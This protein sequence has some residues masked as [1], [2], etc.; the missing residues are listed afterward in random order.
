VLAFVSLEGSVEKPDSNG[1]TDGA[2]GGK[3]RNG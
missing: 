3:E 2:N 1:Q